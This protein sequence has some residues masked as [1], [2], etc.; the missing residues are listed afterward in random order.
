MARDVADRRLPVG[1]FGRLRLPRSGPHRGALDLKGAGG[2][3]LVGAAR[4]HALALGLDET[5]TIERFRA[6]GAH[7][8]YPPDTVIEIAD[9]YEDLLRLRLAHQLARLRTGLAPDNHVE[10]RRLSHRDQL[11]LRE[12]LRTAGRVQAGLRERFATDFA[13]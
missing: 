6:A 10:V 3:Q 12:A 9:A 7:G 11:L 4:V 1:L 13:P 2:L 8:L 5:G